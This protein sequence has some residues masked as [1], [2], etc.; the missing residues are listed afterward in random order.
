M[1][2]PFIRTEWLIGPAALSQLQN[3]KVAVFGVGGVGAHA[4]EALARSGIGALTLIDHDVVD[5]SNINRQLH[6]L[7]STVGQPKVQLMQARLLD[8]NPNLKEEALSTVLRPGDTDAYALSQDY[9]YIVDAV[10]TITTKVT[11]A[12][13]ARERGIPLISA[14]G[15]GNRT[16]PT[17]LGVT[18]VF[19]TKG[20]GCP[21]ARKMRKFLRQQN[22]DKLKVV[23]SKEKPRKVPDTYRVGDSGVRYVGSIAFVPAVAGMLLA[24][25]V[26]KDLGIAPV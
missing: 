10:D 8:I 22:V 18:D 11:I 24:G 7:H 5:P 14:M 4:A 20:Y 15:A 25:E 16:D 26:V 6:A 1:S 23:Y 19:K 2:N 13:T 17:Q 12:L 21:V 9:D 3:S